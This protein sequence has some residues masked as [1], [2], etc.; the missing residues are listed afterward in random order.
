MAASCVH[1][2]GRKGPE[3]RGIP[4]AWKRARGRGGLGGGRGRGLRAARS[5]ALKGD[6][7]DPGAQAVQSGA[8]RARWRKSFGSGA[9]HEAPSPARGLRGALMGN[10]E[11]RSDG[12]EGTGE[13]P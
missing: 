2:V 11:N 13:P 5:A 9:V 6:P 7:G 8:G 12:V 10:P 3:I 1:L 4:Q